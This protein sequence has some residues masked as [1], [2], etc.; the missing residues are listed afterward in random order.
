M[1]VLQKRMNKDTFGEVLARV[2][3]RLA[4]WKSCVLSM[5]GRLTLTKSVLSSIPVH[6]MSSVMLPQSTLSSLDKI[7]RSFLWGSSVEKKKQHLLS[8]KRVCRPKREGGLG[9]RS[10]K[11]MNLALVVKVGWRLLQDEHSLWARVVRKKY[12]L[13]DLHDRT[14]LIPKSTWS[15]LWRG[16]A[17]G[18]KEVIWPGHR[19]VVGDGEQIQ[20]WL[21]S[22]LSDR[23]LI[24][25]A[26]GELPGNA[27][28]LLAKDMWREG[29][30]WDFTRIGPF[31]P[32]N[33]KL[34]LMAVV[35][36]HVIGATDRI[37]WKGSADGEFSVSSAYRLIT[38]DAQ[39]RQDMASFFDR[40][41]HVV[42]PERVRLFLWLT[43]HQVL[44]TNVERKRC[45][46]CDSEI[47]TVCKGGFETILHTLRDCPAMAGI[48]ERIVPR[49][50]RQS[51]FQSSLL[52]WLYDNIQASVIVGDIPWFTT[53]AIAVWWGW[54]W[55]CGNVF[56]ENQKCRDRAPAAEWFKLNT[57]GASQGNPGLATAGGV[58]RDGDGRWCSG[59]ALNI[60]RCSAPLAEL[61]GVYYGLMMAWEKQIPRLV[62]EVDL[63][64]VV[65]FLMKGIQNSH[66]LSFLVRLCH[67]FLSKD[68][69]VRVT[70]VFHEAN[71][72]ADGL[73]NHAFSLPLGFHLFDFVPPIIGVDPMGR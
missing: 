51:F 24:H 30:G 18:L 71:R 65:G 9:I 28:L 42:A 63:E 59:F 12:K 40:I 8:W 55:R 64:V 4:G 41:W 3:A 5:A 52:V 54:K 53:F 33:L 34:E 14:W 21:D 72:L 15:A 62:L 17:R 49:H 70:H 11:D 60:G 38:R 1:P 27:Q 47:C 43:S 67:G 50:M 19:W 20:F 39:P 73:A 46:L 22:W 35:L 2:S 37:S 45:H 69:L 6:S 44:M 68:W 56:G 32:E 36:D 48:W 7:S 13:G 16:V 10:S 61:W 29:M 23:P 25:S 58:L 57:D 66:P 31:L 26:T